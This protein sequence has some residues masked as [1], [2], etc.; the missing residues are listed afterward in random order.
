[1]SDIAE[2]ARFHPTYLPSSSELLC[3]ILLS[4]TVEVVLEL[5]PSTGERERRRVAKVSSSDRVV[6]F[7]LVEQDPKESH[8]GKRRAALFSLQL[9]VSACRAHILLDS[10]RKNA[11]LRQ[12]LQQGTETTANRERREL[13]RVMDT[14]SLCGFLST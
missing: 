3:P 4:D 10:E 6:D 9:N 14:K 1:M 11:E 7:H 12:Q 13:E 8:L 2:P 5:L